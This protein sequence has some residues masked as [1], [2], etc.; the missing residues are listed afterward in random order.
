MIAAVNPLG[1]DPFALA[2]GEPRRIGDRTV[3]L[4]VGR[5]L[6]L[7]PANRRPTSTELYERRLVR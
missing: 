1:R 2:A 3:D 6:G 5:V 7:C 4:L